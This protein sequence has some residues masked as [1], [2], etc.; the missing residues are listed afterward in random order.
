MMG[1]NPAVHALLLPPDGMIDLRHSEGSL[2]D[3]GR[4]W[5]IIIMT[6][7]AIIM[8][9]MARVFVKYGPD[10][11]LVVVH[12]AKFVVWPVATTKRRGAAPH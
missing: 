4:E 3:D 5:G 9:I 6:L 8:L 2:H 12:C 11:R 10:G 7:L 1:I